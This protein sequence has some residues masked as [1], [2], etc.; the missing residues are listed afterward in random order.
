VEV[1]T[2]LEDKYDSRTD[3]DKKMKTTLE[4]NSSKFKSHD[5]DLFYAQDKTQNK[6][7]HLPCF[8]FPHVL[9]QPEVNR[10]NGEHCLLFLVNLIFCNTW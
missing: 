10:L 3:K 7:Q 2:N 9:Q 8:F 6:A 4:R 1:K 5:Q